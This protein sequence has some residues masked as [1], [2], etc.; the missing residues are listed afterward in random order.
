M[1]Q[2]HG[3]E[4]QVEE[5]KGHAG[6]LSRDEEKEPGVVTPRIHHSPVKPEA[7]TQMADSGVP[8]FLAGGGQKRGSLGEWNGDRRKKHAVQIIK[9]KKKKKKQSTFTNFFLY[10]S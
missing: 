9:K 7:K 6:V 4:F 8:T 5:E 2:R 1:L 3:L 10:Y